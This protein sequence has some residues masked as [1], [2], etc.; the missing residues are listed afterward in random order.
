MKEI[1]RSEGLRDIPFSEQ[2]NN[3]RDRI[4]R[5]LHIPLK[6][7]LGEMTNA[8]PDWETLIVPTDKESAV[9]LTSESDEKESVEVRT[10]K[11]PVY[12]LVSRGK[13]TN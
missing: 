11:K 9:V 8:Y 10:K 12:E 6:G 7:S 2:K 13:C 3:H 1:E 5:S 4:L